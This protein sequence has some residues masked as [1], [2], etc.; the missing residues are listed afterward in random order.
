VKNLIALPFFFFGEESCR[1][2][3]FGGESFNAAVFGEELYNSAVLVEES[4][5]YLFTAL[6]I[7]SLQIFALFNSQHWA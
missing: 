3:V 4:N 5:S 6:V 7:D 2:D 1:A